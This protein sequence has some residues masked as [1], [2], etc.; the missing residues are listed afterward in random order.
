[1]IAGAAGIIPVP[2]IDFAAISAVQMKMCHS[3]GQVYGYNLSDHML[4][5]A[6]GSIVSGN[7]AT[8]TGKGIGLKIAKSIPIVGG[9]A[10]ILVLPAMAAAS[11]YALGKVF[12]LHFES[13]G[14]LL[15][16]N[17]ADVK[18]AYE[19]MYTDRLAVK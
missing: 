6:I 7:L 17:A 18:A 8:A 9:I 19:K 5:S 12:V 2:F 1:M 4:K 16:F 14:T 10:S 11:T 15:N 13:G 3:L